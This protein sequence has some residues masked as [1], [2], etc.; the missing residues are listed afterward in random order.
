M[1]RE[2]QPLI[3]DAFP[4][5]RPFCKKGKILFFVSFALF[6]VKLFS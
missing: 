6:A 3:F 4:A 1:S 2:W 5:G